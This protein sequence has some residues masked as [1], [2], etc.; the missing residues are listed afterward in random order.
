MELA[1]TK[2]SMLK[3][4]DG[5]G[6][7]VEVKRGMLWLTQEG[8]TRDRYITAGDWLRLDGD[9]LAIANALQRT[10]LSI[11]NAEGADARL[12]LLTRD[13]AGHNV[14]MREPL[15]ARLRRLIFEPQG[16]MG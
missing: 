8:D 7:V 1:L 13:E 16:A 12:P 9:G 11:S 4:E 10:M 3:I 14:V 15:L 5:R 2:G 6:M